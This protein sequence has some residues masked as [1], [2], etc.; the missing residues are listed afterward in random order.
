MPI[1]KPELAQLIDPVDQIVLHDLS[2]EGVLPEILAG[3]SADGTTGEIPGGSAA[4]S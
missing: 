3:P 2:A 1:W 4:P